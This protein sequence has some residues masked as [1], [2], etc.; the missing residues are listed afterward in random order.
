MQ[1][2]NRDEAQS[3][4]PELLD[5][6][7]RGEEIYIIGEGV[8]RVQLVPVEM[9]L[10]RRQFGSAKGRITMIRCPSSGGR[11]SSRL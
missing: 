1:Q 11:S 7:L 2:V 6:A 5:A 10:K 4:L 9:P 8:V 3:R